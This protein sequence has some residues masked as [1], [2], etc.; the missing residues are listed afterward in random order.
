MCNN[1]NNN[2]KLIQLIQ[3]PKKRE[4][5][6]ESSHDLNKPRWQARLQGKVPT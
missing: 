5:K 1:N 6:K 3:T 2:K 4:L